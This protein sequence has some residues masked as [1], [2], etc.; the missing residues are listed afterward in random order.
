MPAH[1]N[2]TIAALSTVAPFDRMPARDLLTLAPHVD[3]LDLPAGAV[4]AR[5]GATARELVVVLAG[6]VVA[7][8]G[9]APTQRFGPGTLIGER[10]LSERR[11]HDVTYRAATDVSL[12]V[13]NG[14]AFRFAQTSIAA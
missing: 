6:N 10:P 13:V 7:S 5:E 4:L 9:D 1:D 2:S 12:L 11:Q 8:R 3:Q 14:P